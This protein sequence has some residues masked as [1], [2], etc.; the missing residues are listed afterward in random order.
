MSPQT[1]LQIVKDL[2]TRIS[3]I[4]LECLLSVIV[5]DVSQH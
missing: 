5:R 1:F 2:N 3:Q 4:E